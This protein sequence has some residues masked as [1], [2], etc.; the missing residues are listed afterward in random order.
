MIRFGLLASH[1]W[2]KELPLDE[3]LAGLIDLVQ[4]ARDLSQ[5]RTIEF[6]QIDDVGPHGAVTLAF[7]VSKP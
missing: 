1:Q 5:P 4:T 7:A 2:P 6:V 3:S